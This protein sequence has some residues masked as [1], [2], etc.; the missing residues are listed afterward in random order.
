MTSRL[1][2]LTL[3][4]ASCLAL[5]AAASE[6]PADV[7]ETRNRLLQAA[8]QTPAE[9]I[10]VLSEALQDER[11]AIRLT[12]IHLL[13]K[14]GEPAVNAI[15]AALEHPDHQVRLVAIDAL[16]ATDHLAE[17]WPMILM[18]DHPVVRRYA[19]LS[20]LDTHPLPEGEAFDR[21]MTRLRE[22]FHTAPAR[23]RQTLV[24]FFTSM[25][26]L[27]PQ[28][29]RI[30]ATA[31]GDPDPNVRKAAYTG[32]VAHIGAEWPEDFSNLLTTELPPTLEDTP[33]KKGQ[34]SV[35]VWGPY[36]QAIWNARVAI[37]LGRES[38]DNFDE[39][40]ALAGKIQLRPYAVYAQTCIMDRKGRQ[41]EAL[42]AAFADEDIEAWPE[43]STGG[44]PYNAQDL[45][46]LP[47]FFRGLAFHK[48]GNGAAA[49]ADFA[50]ALRFPAHWNDKL[51][52]TIILAKV[53]NQRELLNDED[54][55]YATLAEVVVEEK[56]KES[57]EFWQITLAAARY[58]QER[59][60][61]DEA[62]QTL[63]KLAP[64]DLRGDWQDQALAACD[65]ILQA[66]T[67]SAAQRQAATTLKQQLEEN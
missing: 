37:A 26:P 23:K 24:E 52:Y 17:N 57:R 60:R 46:V 8:E 55:A 34:S 14:I 39:A 41:S 38:N 61:Y 31:T 56:P 2:S 51:R 32:I 7:L 59:N 42:V 40:M 47:L 9:A 30:V 35:P 54:G 10:P 48:V 4:L 12:A 11:P 45:R 27:T 6:S 22:I 29:A 64:Q 28:A 19:S 36:D 62:I 49:D 21:F 20:L 58:L 16:A 3:I 44:A 50:A 1:I 25:D 33:R 65:E 67:I 63:W 66:E 13:E 43:L 5:A 15:E 53:K 18:D